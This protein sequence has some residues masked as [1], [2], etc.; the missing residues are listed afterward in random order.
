MWTKATQPKVLG[1]RLFEVLKFGKNVDKTPM[2]L[3]KASTHD[4]NFLL[5]VAVKTTSL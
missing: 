3:L 5:C 4:G 1:A 2:G